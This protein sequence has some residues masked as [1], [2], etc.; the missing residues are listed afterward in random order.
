MPLTQLRALLADIL[1][2][3][4]NAAIDN[5]FFSA[6][7]PR[8]VGAGVPVVDYKQALL[9]HAQAGA[10][11][12][13]SRGVMAAAVGGAGSG[14]VGGGV[15]GVAPTAAR[16]SAADRELVKAVQEALYSKRLTIKDAFR[17]MDAD[18]DGYISTQE[19]AMFLG[20]ELGVA[21]G[22]EAQLR[23]VLG[24]DVA[25]GGGG[26]GVGSASAPRDSNSRL[27]YSRLRQVFG[28]RV[29]AQPRQA[30]WEEGVFRQVRMIVIFAYHF[31]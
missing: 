31:Q 26:G 13:S 9:P 10:G 16:L 3:W 19:L 27:A 21:S 24:M 4:S 22:G 5:V 1:V 12:E 15:G 11:V 28:A 23:S 29:S 18:K 14:G 7:Q 20:K 8:Q 6:V 30:D 2:G 25:S 17:T